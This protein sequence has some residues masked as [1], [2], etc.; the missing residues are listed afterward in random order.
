MLLVAADG[1]VWFAL[2][3]SLS[4]VM[5]FSVYRHWYNNSGGICNVVFI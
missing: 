1:L 2:H 4:L 5:H 3:I